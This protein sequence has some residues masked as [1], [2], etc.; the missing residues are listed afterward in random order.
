MVDDIQIRKKSSETAF[1]LPQ[2]RP[3]RWI[4]YFSFYNARALT[5]W[6]ITVAG[7]LQNLA[8]VPLTLERFTQKRN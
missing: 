8:K 5:K 4:M 3:I 1:F 6:K 2:L 7:T